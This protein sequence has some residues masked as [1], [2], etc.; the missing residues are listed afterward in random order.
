MREKRKTHCRIRP[1]CCV[2]HGTISWIAAMQYLLDD[3]SH[4][5]DTAE[6][7]VPGDFHYD[8]RLRFR[9]R[10]NEIQYRCMLWSD[11][12]GWSAYVNSADCGR[13]ANMRSFVPVGHVCKCCA[14]GAH[15][16]GGLE[17]RV[18]AIEQMLVKK[19]NNKKNPRS[20]P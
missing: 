9:I 20:E 1:C 3:P 15:E 2:S 4:E 7:G 10:D 11:P 16:S 14:C 19:S 17:A 18:A 13:S 6:R 12:E 8:R 5:V